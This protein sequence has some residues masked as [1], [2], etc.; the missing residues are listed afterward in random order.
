MFAGAVVLR[1]AAAV[2]GIVRRVWRPG[3][4]RE[5]FEAETDFW[6]STGGTLAIT[7]AD[8]PATFV[9]QTNVAG[10]GGYGHFNLASNGAWTYTADTARDEFIAG[11]T[12]TDT[13]RRCS[14]A[15]GTPSTITVTILGTNDAAVIALPAASLTE[16]NAITTGGTLAMTDVDS[17]AAFVAQTNVAGSANYGHFTLAANGAWTYATDTAHNE[18]VAGPTYTDTLAVVSADGTPSTIT[19]TIL[20]TN[21]AAVITPATAWSTEHNTD[22][23]HRRRAGHF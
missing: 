13:L 5:F 12:Y 3:E 1:R 4:R 6:M 19:V 21:D 15:D 9:A 10:A 2:G 11:Q 23:V 20:G 8:S 7:D 18:F 17:P 16:T 22:A 14:S